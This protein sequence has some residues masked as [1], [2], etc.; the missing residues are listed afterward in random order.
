MNRIAAA[1]CLILLAVSLSGCVTVADRRDDLRA[2]FRNQVKG[3]YVL[4]KPAVGL[5]PV[6]VEVRL[7]PD[8]SL[9]KAPMVIEGT[10]DSLT[11][12]AALQA[13][14]NCTPF[15]IPAGIAGRYP[16]WKVMRIRFDTI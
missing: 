8:G 7:K 13:V 10:P 3:C 2:V 1:S 6:V 5:K 15:E 12:R 16:D 4:P 11:G 9:A 14:R